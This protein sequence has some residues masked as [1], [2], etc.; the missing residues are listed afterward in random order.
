MNRKI[1]V[2]ILLIVFTSVIAFLLSG[3]ILFQEQD[4]ITREEAIDII[5]EKYP[6]ANAE[7]RFENQCETGESCWKA[8]FVDNETGSMVSVSIGSSSGDY[9]EEVTECAE[10]WCDAPPCNYVIT[11]HGENYTI[12]YYNSGCS[13]PIQSCNATYS[14]CGVCQT[15]PDCIRRIVTDYG[16]EVIHRFEVIETE[17]YGVINT[18]AY[19]CR[20]YDKSQ[21]KIFE[22]TTSVSD[23]EFIITY[24]TKCAYDECDFIPSY[25]LIPI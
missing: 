25:T 6:G 18:T 10:W 15:K 7:P 13:S 5:N 12:T 16:S 1:L 17:A 19:E 24:Y 8:D 21:E 14:V 22:N 20:I 23:C 4:Q 9:S 11:E 3:G 2:I